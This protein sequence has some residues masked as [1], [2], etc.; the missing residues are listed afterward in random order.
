MGAVMRPVT[1]SH[2]I[3]R[4]KLAYVIDAT[5]APVCMIAPVSS[6]AAAVSGY[7][8]S[9]SINGIELFIKQIPW[10]YYCLLDAGDFSQGSSYVSLSE[11]ATAIELMN[12]VG[13]DAVALGNHEFDYGFEALKKNMESLE[14]AI[15]SASERFCLAIFFG[16][17][18]AP[19]I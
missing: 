4:A 16:R 15:F 2:K 12:M 14:V 18:S 9:D 3:S 1:E 7:V 11:G 10:N 19:S 13:Y 5:A 8:Q 6:W 17:I